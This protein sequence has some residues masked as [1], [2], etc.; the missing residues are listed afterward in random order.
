MNKMSVRDANNPMPT[1]YGEAGTNRSV[2]LNISSTITIYH[3]CKN[4][5]IRVIRKVR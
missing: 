1:G 2:N 5:D 3:T 4:V